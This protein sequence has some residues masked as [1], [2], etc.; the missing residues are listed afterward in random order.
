[1]RTSG[2]YSEEAEAVGGISGKAFLLAPWKSVAGKF[3]LCVVIS[4]WLLRDEFG[5]TVPLEQH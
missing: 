4:A 2:F 5:S 3:S 1:M